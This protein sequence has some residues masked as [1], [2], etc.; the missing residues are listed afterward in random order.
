M[1]IDPSILAA[2]SAGART[3]SA[4]NQ[5]AIDA[6]EAERANP[7]K[8]AGAWNLGQWAIDVLSTGGYAT[9]GIAN[10][11]GQNVA[12]AK[13]G[14]VGGILDALN[15][16]SAAPAAMRGIAE[17]RTYSQ[18]LKDLGAN[19]AVATGLGL[20]L[21]I[22]LDPTTYITG[23]M[24]AGV[25]GAAQGVKLAAAA[26]KTG[27]TIAKSA[28]V[29]KGAA[30]I[31]RDENL[32][33]TA[34]AP[35]SSFVSVDRP[36][37]QS[38][39]VGNLLTGINRGY[40]T[41]KVQYSVAKQSDKVRRLDNRQIKRLEKVDEA[42]ELPSALIKAAA[43]AD[44]ARAAQA[45]T[46]AKA[47]G[48]AL[49]EVKAGTRKTKA[50]A[51]AN[52]GEAL[53]AVAD[54]ASKGFEVIL[55]TADGIVAE[56]SATGKFYKTEKLANAAGQKALAKLKA[57][58]ADGIAPS[59]Q[60]GTA[61]VTADET[62]RQARIVEEG[63]RRELRTIQDSL[64]PLSMVSKGL[65]SFAQ[66]IALPGSYLT[67]LK[68][69]A[70]NLSKTVSQVQERLA[71]LAN[72]ELGSL[73]TSPE[74]I[75][76]LTSTKL[77]SII[78]KAATDRTPG[79]QQIF[80]EI[81][82][83]EISIPADF[84]D[85]AATVA[86]TLEDEGVATLVKSDGT[87]SKIKTAT[88]PERAQW[89]ADINAE[90]VFK[91]RVAQNLKLVKD[92]QAELVALEKQIDL[93]AA[94]YQKVD[95]ALLA[96]GK[97]TSTASA[98]LSKE[99]EEL[100]KKVDT[101][102]VQLSDIK[103][104]N[105]PLGEGK[106]GWWTST[107]KMTAEDY[108]AF[109][110]KTSGEIPELDI[111]KIKTIKKGASENVDKTVKA[112]L[113]KDDRKR[114]IEINRLLPSASKADKEL[115][116]AERAKITTETKV[117]AFLAAELTPA[118]K[119]EKADR[120]SRSGIAETATMSMLARMTK[121]TDLTVRSQAMEVFASGRD[122]LA[123][124]VAD[125]KVE[126]KPWIDEIVTS[127]DAGKGAKAFIRFAMPELKSTSVA[128][129]AATKLMEDLLE[130]KIAAAAGGKGVAV[131]AD[132]MAQVFEEF[133]S[134]RDFTKVMDELGRIDLSKALEPGSYANVDDMAI[135]LQDGKLILSAPQ[136]ASLTKALGIAV[137]TTEAARR[138][139][140]SHTDSVNSLLAESDRFTDLR[141]AAEDYIQLPGKA[142]ITSKMVAEA[143]GNSN[144]AAMATGVDELM[145]V[146]KLQA[147]MAQ[148]VDAVRAGEEP[149]VVAG[150]SVEAQAKVNQ[151]REEASV[152]LNDK[153]AVFDGPIR[154]EVIA[155]VVRKLRDKVFPDLTAR[156][157]EIA[158]NRGESVE[159]LL[160][161]AFDGSWTSI[162]EDADNLIMSG[163][164]RTT[165]FSTESRF[166]LYGELAAGGNSSLYRKGGSGAEI[167]AR[168]MKVIDLTEELA[169]VFGL[170][171]Q[172]TETYAATLR[173]TGI[174]TTGDKLSVNTGLRS[175]ITYT[176]IIESLNAT[177][178]GGNDL[179]WEL[180]RYRG[181]QGSK[182]AVYKQGNFPPN[183][184][185]AA[186]LT[187]KSYR[188]D[189]TF[190]LAKGTPEYDEIMF[191]LSNIYEKPASA[192]RNVEVSTLFAPSFQTR[193]ASTLG[194]AEAA[195][196]AKASDDI[197]KH[198]SDNFDSLAELDN[199]RSLQAFSQDLPA[200]YEQ[201]SQVMLGML[202]Y[203]MEYKAVKNGAIAANTL[204][205]QPAMETFGGLLKDHEKL[206]DTLNTQ[207][208]RDKKMAV[209]ANDMITN[210]MVNAKFQNSTGSADV[211]SGMP[212]VRREISRLL[213][214]KI[215]MAKA[216]T[217][218]KQKNA[219]RKQ[220]DKNLHEDTLIT[221]KV[222]E[223]TGHVSEE[224]A[225]MS[226]DIEVAVRTHS[227]NTELAKTTSIVEKFGR[228][229]NAN[230]MSQEFKT[231]VNAMEMSAY[232]NGHGFSMIA[233][234]MSKLWKKRG[235]E[236][237]KSFSA[238]QKYR[239]AA[240]AA[241]ETGNDI[242][243]I[244]EWIATNGLEVDS[245]MVHLFDVMTKGLFGSESAYGVASRT[246]LMTDELNAQLSKAGLGSLRVTDG[247]DIDTFWTRI[248]I[249]TLD[250]KN[251]LKFLDQ[252]NGAVTRAIG[253]IAFGE[254]LSSQ[255]GKTLKQLEDAGE[256]V[257]DYVRID[258]DDVIGRLLTDKDLLFHKDVIERLRY[259][260]DYFTYDKTFGDGALAQIVGVSD[261]FVSNLKATQTVL[262]PAHWVVSTVGEAAMNWLAGVKTSSYGPVFRLM[263][264]ID[265][266]TVGKDFETAIEAL[267]AKSAPKNMKLR[268]GATQDVWF[269]KGDKRVIVNDELLVK[270]MM[271]NGVI[272]TPYASQLDD[273][274][275]AGDSFRKGI[276][277][278]IQKLAAKLSPLAAKRDNIF[279]MAHFIDELKRSKAPTFEEAAQLAATRVREWHPTVGSLSAAEQKY[280]RRL[281]YFYTWQ[282]TA[283]VK[284]IATM[285]E[286]P[287]IATIPSK[288]QYAIAD[289]NGLN[290]ESFGDPWDPNGTY[291]SYHTGQ[292]WGP[293][294]QG[295]DGKGDAWGIQPSIQP[296]DVVGQ[297]FKPFTLQ[298]GQSPIDS[299]FQGAND[300]FAGNLNPVIK[301]LMESSA[302]SR[303]GSGADLP[304]P[305]EYL[306]SQV[307]VLSTL[308]KVTGVG[309]DEN[310]YETPE[311]RAIN[312]DRLISNFFSGQRMT[313]YNSGGTDYKWKLDQQE[314]LKRMTGQ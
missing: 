48:I 290:P 93:K 61:P 263:E 149:Q 31:L 266:G 69:N 194:G 175:N 62:M 76:K 219:R 28:K 60:V 155:S 206:I 150:I 43:R 102:N 233:E 250:G 242:E 211:V 20:A 81:A 180:R 83:Q 312:N 68:P 98:K 205:K 302:K 38:E 19:D 184:I 271:D 132:D 289:Y 56:H 197:I 272:M 153:L 111:P 59:T 154:G 185:E 140:T 163:A 13:R 188:S 36:L 123:K 209:F 303:L 225:M 139:I 229:F 74:A 106:Y 182:N 171:V 71:Q 103:Q 35:E 283:L 126:L 97:Q 51:A 52:N 195:S 88:K 189:P 125:G 227:V 222:I 187:I 218:A 151:L 204:A 239:Q 270:A 49:P 301:M 230:I 41:G 95:S 262:R 18:N 234:A 22:G 286:K 248:N 292:L 30:T 120:V 165:E 207:A 50:A 66:T 251:P 121:S 109:V 94:Q 208:F 232:S 53:T 288:V 9:A 33:A 260:N 16:F 298:P 214:K 299:F 124:S 29:E 119:A 275:G 142:P 168:E 86:R 134:G 114:L 294:W 277:A 141:Q 192:A 160:Q 23:G 99:L 92:T 238:V 146:S 104:G 14:E 241:A 63:S 108:F 135:D 228:T 169:R 216:T 304:S 113:S 212:A 55:R 166:G 278:P 91:D 25:K 173:R 21:D 110:N 177:G 8:A 196:I 179:I 198:L 213:E 256:T 291:A 314:M 252:I 158:K 178:K 186:W 152:R 221:V 122:A 223:E 145:D 47:S 217:P 268:A 115:L 79:E 7:A 203:S 117:P 40:K 246:G 37:T 164:F 279:R 85:L 42:V 226:D 157:A 243:D 273:I 191:S 274:V 282:K 293:Q 87:T 34:K 133:L 84:N 32:L 300:T 296:I 309:Q 202:K 254:T 257:A 172:S 167:F 305:T 65:D 249:E 147:D 143:S 54:K 161:K 311:E 131:S 245:D 240:S 269:V 264:Q 156:I 200:L 116:T 26:T 201:A 231:A 3:T 265:P 27:S 128:F 72:S 57:E 64:T 144:G 11:V 236:V 174:T 77:L 247:S 258:A 90:Q 183:A 78:K 80:E 17:R 267:V 2:L 12:A 6:Y 137:D 259:V 308:S 237:V 295:P 75:G 129:K 10:K 215:A 112:E 105:G 127:N 193:A 58:A 4:S 276:F 310:P 82:R 89:A 46:A 118:A 5:S 307:G 107:E 255:V 170:P 244:A 162:A 210:T 261:G 285:L 306:I 235:P 73:A 67:G 148:T 1:A 280:G 190:V 45:A 297:V 224:I 159:D 199:Y 181:P 100:G 24:L 287:G 138:A 130:G 44:K 70:K 313:D 176:D 253:Q 15:P 220:T 281:V 284:V 101:K 39:K 136:L 96:A